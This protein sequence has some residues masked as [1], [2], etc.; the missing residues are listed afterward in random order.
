MRVAWYTAEPTPALGINSIYP[1]VSGTDFSIGPADAPVTLVLYCDFQS[2][3]CKGMETVVTELIKNHDDLRFVFRPLP[4]IG[5]MDKSELAIL[6]ALAADEQGK[7]WA[8]YDLLFAKYNEWTVL[9]STCA[10]DKK[11]SNG[12]K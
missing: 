6:A 11:T 3:G 5:I 8:M 12:K 1:P 9:A 2:T 10:E 7:F 4:L